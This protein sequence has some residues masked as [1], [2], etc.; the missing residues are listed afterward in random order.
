MLQASPAR[1]ACRKDTTTGKT[2]QNPY[3]TSAQLD[4]SKSCC[5]TAILENRAASSVWQL[6]GVRDNPV[7]LPVQ[8]VHCTTLQVS[9]ELS[10]RVISFWCCLADDDAAAAAAAAAVL[11]LLLHGQLH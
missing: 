4:C 10:S 7:A 9:A 8:L 3:C 5:L 6:H 2:L 11:Q 1:C